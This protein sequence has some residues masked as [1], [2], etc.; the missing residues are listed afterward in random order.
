MCYLFN[1]KDWLQSLKLG[2][3]MHKTEL[4][5]ELKCIIYRR[6]SDKI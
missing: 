2:K 3:Y 1:G 5:F 4:K 6:Y